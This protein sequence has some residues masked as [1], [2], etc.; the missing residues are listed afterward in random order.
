MMQSLIPFIFGLFAAIQTASVL[1]VEISDLRGRIHSLISKKALLTWSI[2][3]NKMGLRTWILLS[4][5]NVPPLM[6]TVAARLRL[7]IH[8]RKPQKW[9]NVWPLRSYN[10]LASLS[11]KHAVWSC[12]QTNVCA[13]SDQLYCETSRRDFPLPS[14]ALTDRILVRMR[15][16]Y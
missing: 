2:S 16:R 10:L 6:C 1:R 9:A 5:P 8:N 7:H 15:Y 3:A 11:G 13:I 4:H 12:A 14:L